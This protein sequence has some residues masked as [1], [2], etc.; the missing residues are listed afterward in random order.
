MQLSQSIFPLKT[1]NLQD[2][3]FPSHGNHLGWI[4]LVVYILQHIEPHGEETLLPLTAHEV[5]MIL[6]GTNIVLRRES[7]ATTLLADGY[8]WNA[9]VLRVVTLRHNK[10][11]AILRLSR[12]SLLRGCAKTPC[13]CRCRR[14][15]HDQ[16]CP[17]SPLDMTREVTMVKLVG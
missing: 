11:A 13:P 6:G 12:N 8:R 15:L 16:H 14:H 9:I 4:K 2:F 3:S 1:Y 10:C 17:H 5:S 7:H